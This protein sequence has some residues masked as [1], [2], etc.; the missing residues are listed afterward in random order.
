MSSFFILVTIRLPSVFSLCL[1]YL[2]VWWLMVM[3]STILKLWMVV[4]P[5]GY[6]CTCHEPHRVV[7]DIP[8]W[9]RTRATRSHNADSVSA[10]CRGRGTDGPHFR[11]LVSRT[12]ELR[13]WPVYTIPRLSS[14]TDVDYSSRKK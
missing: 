7:G 1:Y 11:T 4:R 14:I 6:C 9:A 10:L 5:L 12:P 2:R 3:F 13:V 8:R